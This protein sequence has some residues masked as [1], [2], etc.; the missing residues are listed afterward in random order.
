MANFDISRR[1][2][3]GGAAAAFVAVAV[4]AGAATAG[5]LPAGAAQA[6]SRHADLII[7]T[8]EC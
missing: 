1:R 4:P 8:D 3:L 5:V 6:H 7:H 2:V